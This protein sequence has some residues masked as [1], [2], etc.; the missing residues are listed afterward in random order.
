MFRFL[1]EGVARDER[2]RWRLSEEA[3]V[4]NVRKRRCVFP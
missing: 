1:S 2:W 4:Q 3:D